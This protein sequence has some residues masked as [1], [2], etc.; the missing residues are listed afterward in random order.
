MEPQE[1]VKYLLVEVRPGKQTLIEPL[2]THHRPLGPLWFPSPVGP[3]NG[4]V[5]GALVLPLQ[6]QI[7][8]LAEQYPT[9]TAA[10][11]LNHI[12]KGC[13]GSDE[14]VVTSSPDAPD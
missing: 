3:H 10:E 2:Q 11:W 12:L 5:S 4:V 14:V 1:D 13:V 7:R 9:P 6:D 8:A